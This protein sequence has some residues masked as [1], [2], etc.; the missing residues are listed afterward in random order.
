MPSGL[1][2]AIDSLRQFLADADPQRVTTSQAADLVKDFVELERLA[3][4]GKMLFAGRAAQATTWADEGYSN[5]AFWLAELAKMPVGNAIDTLK[6]SRRIEKL[7]GTEQAVRAGKLSSAQAS[8]ISKAS[9]K[10][11]S[12]ER[13]LLRLADSDTYRRLKECADQVLAQAT[14]AEDE[15][16]RARAI[17]ARRSLRHWRDP[18][19]AF[20]LDARLTPEAG[21]RLLSSI[22]TEADAIFEQARKAGTE[23]PPEAYRADALVALVTGAAHT[24]QTKATAGQRHSGRGGDTIVIRIDATALRRGHVGSGEV[25]EIA[26]VGPVDVATV[27]RLLPPAYVKVVIRNSVD[28]QSVC[29]VGRAIPAHA[30][31]SLQERDRTCVVPSCDVAKG[32]EA[33]HWKEDFASSGTTSVGEL[34]LV[35][36]RHHD[37]ITYRGYVLDGGPGRWRFRG[38]PDVEKLRQEPQLADTG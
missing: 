18:E 2:K 15:A 17:H 10:D 5:P 30:F 35:C 36:A 4:S 9:E 31:T 34:A 8:D 25:C 13:S 37:M 7:P 12:A 24:S 19:G 33:H 1:G 16:E 23:E 20:R 26:G 38:P 32:L 29:H 11:P 27:R 3:T 28:V 6:T 14:S 21:S 22:Q